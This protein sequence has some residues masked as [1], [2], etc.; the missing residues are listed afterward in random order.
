[1]RERQYFRSIYFSEP[2]GV[3]FEIATAG[4]GFTL[5]EAPEALG[6]QLMLPAWLEERRGQIA[7]ALPPFQL[8]LIDQWKE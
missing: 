3:V 4:P 8:P 2:G 7:A 5:D 6:T 1:M